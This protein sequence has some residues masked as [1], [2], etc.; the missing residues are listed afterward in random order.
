MSSAPLAPS[1]VYEVLGHK[2]INVVIVAV[3]HAVDVAQ[4]IVPSHLLT[5]AYPPL[6]VS[7]GIQRRSYDFGRC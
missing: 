1:G 4:P 2:L 5:V 6:G 7:L 3:V